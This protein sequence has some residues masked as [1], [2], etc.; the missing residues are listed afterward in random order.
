VPPQETADL[1]PAVEALRGTAVDVLYR[2]DIKVTRAPLVAEI[3]KDL[4]LDARAAT[5]GEAELAPGRILLMG[6]NPRWFKR[7]LGRVA[8]LPA[9]QRP[10]VVVWHTEGLPMP[11]AAGYPL[12]RLTLRE[13][14]K[15][16]LRDRRI[17]DQYSNARY[18]RRLGR[19][20]IVTVLAV[21]SKA[22]QD[23]LAEHGIV[24][25]EF[26]PI[27]NHPTYG[28][29]LGLERDIPVLFLGEHGIRRRRKILERLRREGVDVL[30]L[31]SSS[32]TK[33]TWGEAR[34]E[35]LNRTK[36]LLNLPRYP[37]HLSDRV[38]MGMATGALVVSEPMYRPAPFEPG[39]HYVECEV[40]EMA[41]TVRRYL[42]DDEAR[43]R[44]T[45]TAYTFLNDLHTYEGVFARLMELAA[46]TI[47]R[48]SPALG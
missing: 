45:D 18:I 46:R 23:Y 31:G 10:H 4:G 41:E 19:E 9:E 47:G 13:V 26:V 7:T 35:L 20:G 21:V 37:G 25:T 27:G 40:D 30:A 29:L 8:A 38:M 17:N 33:G 12:E 42:A 43:R 32:P 34:T 15:I 2:E 6:G 11:A 24:E 28:R 16:V 36:I 44:I 1:A 48:G 3:L 14:A 39:M 5:E 22:H